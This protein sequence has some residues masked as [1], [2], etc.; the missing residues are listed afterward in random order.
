MIRKV[1]MS[2]VAIVAI[3]GTAFAADLPSR[4][5]PPVYVPPPIPVFSWTG[6]YVGGQVGDDFGKDR[7]TQTGITG[8]TQTFL[9]GGSPN[10]VSGG[11]HVGYNFSTQSLPFF[12]GLGSGLLG[13]GGVIGIEGDVNGSDFRGTTAFGGAV[14]LVETFRKDIDGSIR[15]RLGIAV[16]RALFYATGGAAFAEFHQSYAIGGLAVQSPSSTRVGYTVGGGVEYAIT[17]N[18]SL[19]AEYR[20]SD[21]GRF[22]DLNAPAPFNTTNHITIQQAQVGF[23]YKF[24]NPVAPAPVVARY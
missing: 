18:F 24:D 13:T 23:S 17:T 5:A 20:Y 1:L 11:G 19:R 9:V 3:S 7:A 15:G 16:D 2:T 6:F 8:A 12:G 4:R 22:T 10:G 21:Y 14:P